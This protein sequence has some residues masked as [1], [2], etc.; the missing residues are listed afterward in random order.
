MARSLARRVS[1]TGS[2][3]LAIKWQRRHARG[4]RAG[5]ANA[6]E[7]P[8]IRTGDRIEGPD[9]KTLSHEQLME[10]LHECHRYGSSDDPRVKYT[11]SYCSAVQSAHAMEGYASPSAAVADPTL[12]KLH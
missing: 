5:E 12:N 10:A 6:D 4:I 7:G 2:L 11:I 1:K 8:A 3:R 9:V